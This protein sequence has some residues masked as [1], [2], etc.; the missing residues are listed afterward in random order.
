M[1]DTSKRY[2]SEA[3]KKKLEESK[4]QEAFDSICKPDNPLG[5]W[6]KRQDIIKQNN[7]KADYLY[8]VEPGGQILIT[9]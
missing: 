2:H 9:I 5:E 6:I 8:L 4:I 3:T 1:F 7:D